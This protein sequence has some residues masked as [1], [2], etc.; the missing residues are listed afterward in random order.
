MARAKK[1]RKV[2][3][4][5][6]LDEET[7]AKFVGLARLLGIS[8]SELVER[9]VDWAWAESRY[10]GGVQE[11]MVALNTPKGAEHVFRVLAGE[12]APRRV[13]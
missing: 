5:F 7:Y 9:V 1:P 3:L 10:Y 13:Q 4:R 8:R 12:E 2:P 11:M 6:R